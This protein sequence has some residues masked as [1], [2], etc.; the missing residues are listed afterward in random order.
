MKKFIFVL[1]G[2]FII[3]NFNLLAQATEGI[4]IKE[5]N[6]EIKIYKIG[7]D[8]VYYSQLHPDKIERIGSKSVM[9]NLKNDIIKIGDDMV[10]NS[11]SGKLLKVG[12]KRVFYNGKRIHSIGQDRVLYK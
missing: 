5:L 3:A 12:D 4:C 11:L 2:I 9:Y 8:N 6:K 7:N 1:I 10:V